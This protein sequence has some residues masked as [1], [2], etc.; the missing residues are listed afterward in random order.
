MCFLLISCS[1]NNKTAPTSGIDKVDVDLT[2]LSSTMV[3]AE[4]Y[5]MVNTP[6]NY[7]GKPSV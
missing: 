2:V 7:L 4:V 1:G 5:D 6:D 3:Y